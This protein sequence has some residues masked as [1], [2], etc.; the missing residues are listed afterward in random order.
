MARRRT[1]TPPRSASLTAQRAVR[2]LLRAAPGFKRL[3]AA[4]Q[5]RLVQDLTTLAAQAGIVRSVEFP[6]FVTGLI[7]GVFQAILDSSIR[8]IEAY[9][10]LL[11]T[12]TRSID[13][14]VDDTQATGDARDYLVERFPTLFER[15]ADGTI[16]LI[17]E[18]PKPCTTPRRRVKLS[19]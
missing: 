18:C 1:R 17:G 5:R 2:A 16:A 4:R 19:R 13:R 14:F 9:A 6:A 10:D 15:C 11:A 3:T 8:Q 12:V 7:A